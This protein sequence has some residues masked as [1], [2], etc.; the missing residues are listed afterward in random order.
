[1]FW[2]RATFL[3]SM[4]LREKE[5]ELP[6]FSHVIR[7]QEETKESMKIHH[8]DFPRGLQRNSEWIK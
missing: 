8:T 7:G 6:A 3:G 1:M 5:Y 2:T 4:D